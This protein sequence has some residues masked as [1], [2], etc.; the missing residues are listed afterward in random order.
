MDV[1]ENLIAALEGETPE[2]TPYEISNWY[3]DHSGQVLDEW[4]H[5]FDQGM[6]FVRGCRTVVQEEHGVRTAVERK[7]EH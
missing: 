1:R 6:A 7:L 3:F 4:R 2:W 5:L